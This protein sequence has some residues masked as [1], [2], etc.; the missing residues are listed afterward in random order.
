LL[1]GD[2]LIP[3][4][5]APWATVDGVHPNDLGFY[6]MARAVAAALG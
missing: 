6:A 3:A 2:A 1:T 4:Q 5:I